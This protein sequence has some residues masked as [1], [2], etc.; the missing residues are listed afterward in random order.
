MQYI[1]VPLNPET[2]LQSMSDVYIFILSLTFSDTLKFLII[3]IIYR[4]WKPT[5][6]LDKWFGCLK[7]L[8]HRD[9]TFSLKDSLDYDVKVLC[10]DIEIFTHR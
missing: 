8:F 2:Y 7:M 3:C 9:S 5:Y 4:E 6:F 1:L 10:C